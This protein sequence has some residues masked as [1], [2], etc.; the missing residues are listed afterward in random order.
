MLKSDSGVMWNAKRLSPESVF[1][2]RNDFLK[3]L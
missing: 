1:T 3:K 2:S